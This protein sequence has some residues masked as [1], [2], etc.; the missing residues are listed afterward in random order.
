M[1]VGN[2]SGLLNLR[3]VRSNCE[4]GSKEAAVQVAERHLERAVRVRLTE[5]VELPGLV[6]GEVHLLLEHVERAI[7]VGELR[8]R[9]QYC[10]ALCLRG[11]AVALERV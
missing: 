9:T 5:G 10:D 11:L 2:T 1:R 6:R 4:A 3:V 7:E 8:R